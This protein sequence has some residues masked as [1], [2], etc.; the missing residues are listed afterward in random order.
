MNNSP[1]PVSRTVCGYEI[2]RMPLGRFIRAI[3]KIG[4]IPV[5]MIMAAFPGKTLTE[6]GSQ[7]TMAE[8][9]TAMMRNTGDTVLEILSELLGIDTQVLENDVNIGL[10]GLLEMF[11]AWMELNDIEN[12][13][14][15]VRL[16]A[17]KIRDG[18]FMGSLSARSSSA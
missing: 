10:P 3:D 18:G 9:I 7:A 16:R 2:K 4:R 8:L 12:F 15:A 6:I 11:D 13:T 1:F 17:A 5:E 14:R